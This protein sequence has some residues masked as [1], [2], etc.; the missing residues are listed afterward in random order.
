[1]NY[2]CA[3]VLVAISIM[4]TMDFSILTNDFEIYRFIQINISTISKSNFEHYHKNII[5]PNSHRRNILRLSNTFTVDIVFSSSRI[6]LKFRQFKT[7]IIDNIK[8][9]YLNN[10][11]NHLI[12]LLKLY[13]LVLTFAEYIT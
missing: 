10:I 13:S 3:V 4:F 12:S 8:A 1:M 11:L 6:I 2:Y 5:T 7:L 9:T